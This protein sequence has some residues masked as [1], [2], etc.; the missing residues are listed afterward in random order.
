MLKFIPGLPEFK[1][2][3]SSLFALTSDS[4]FKSSAA[5]LKSAPLL[6]SGAGLLPASGDSYISF[7]FFFFFLFFA[8]ALFVSFLSQLESENPLCRDVRQR[9]FG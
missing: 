4:E 9:V 3:R 6:K 2:S 1:S 7:F 5:F 8:S